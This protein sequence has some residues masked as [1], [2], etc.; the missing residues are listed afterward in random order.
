MD[1]P[2]LDVSYKWNHIKCGLLCLVSFTYNVFE[3]SSPF[4]FLISFFME[5][6]QSPC[7]LA[8][9]GNNLGFQPPDPLD[10]PKSE[11]LPPSG[12]ASPL[13]SHPLW[14]VGQ[15][16]WNSEGPAFWLV[17]GGL[18]VGLLVESP[19]LRCLL[20]VM[21][22]FYSC[23]HSLSSGDISRCLAIFAQG[24]LY[25]GHYQH[26][27]LLQLSFQIGVCLLL[28]S[29]KNTSTWIFCIGTETIGVWLFVYEGEL[30]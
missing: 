27:R 14:R 23:N 29:G 19:V 16:D 6:S 10:W 7:G 17:L 11:P 13:S 18:F 12:R 22:T 4:L 24:T 25:A 8:G 20:L 3:W 21:K 2:F 5:L 9:P 28:G 26:P 15:V 30:P 1:L